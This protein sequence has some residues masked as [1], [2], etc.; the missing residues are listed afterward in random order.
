[1][2]IYA[3]MLFCQYFHI[4]SYVN[5]NLKDLFLRLLKDLRERNF[6][7]ISERIPSSVMKEWVRKRGFPRTPMWTKINRK[8]PINTTPPEN[9]RKSTENIKPLTLCRQISI[10][11]PFMKAIASLASYQKDF[12][13]DRKT[14]AKKNQIKI[15]F[16]VKSSPNPIRHIKAN[17]N[18]DTKLNLI[19][20]DWIDFLRDLM[21]GIAGMGNEVVRDGFTVMEWALLVNLV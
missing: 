16:L 1:M 17:P 10:S 8:S 15:L 4:R 14:N 12:Y 13:W 7:K 20:N 9:F 6:L 11:D 5:Q 3:A 21:A 19:K 18:I 2:G